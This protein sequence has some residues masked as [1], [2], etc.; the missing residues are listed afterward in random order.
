MRALVSK[1][2]DW[3]YFSIFSFQNKKQNKSDLKIKNS[4]LFKEKYFIQNTKMKWIMMKR[5][6]G[7]LGDGIKKYF[8]VL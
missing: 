5:N 4:D 7:R 8:K 2:A 1:T 6:I 3:V